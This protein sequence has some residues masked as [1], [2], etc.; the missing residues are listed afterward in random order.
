VRTQFGYH[1]IKVEER[2]AGRA[3]PFGEAEGQVKEDLTREQTY[4]RYQQY[5]AGLRGKAK[6][7][8]LLQ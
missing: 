5:V 8:V 3:L 2:K 7:E 6:V 4:E 1:I